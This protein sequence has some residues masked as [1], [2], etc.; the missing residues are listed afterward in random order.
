MISSFVH[1][2]PCWLFLDKDPC[3]SVFF[4]WL[5]IAHPA[6]FVAQG[7]EMFHH[8]NASGPQALPQEDAEE[9]SL[10]VAPIPQ[11]NVVARGPRGCQR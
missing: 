7:L 1:I 4:S 5:K 11:P 3:L 6:V 8:E 9:D 2:A 10:E